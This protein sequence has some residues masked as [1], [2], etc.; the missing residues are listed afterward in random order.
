[1]EQSSHTRFSTAGAVVLSVIVAFMTGCSPDY[2]NCDTDDECKAGEF[3]VNNL[4]QQCRNDADCPTGQSCNA[5]ACE[6]VAGYC[7]SNADCDSGEE[8]QDNRCVAV[9]QSTGSGSGGDSGP[10]A[11]T[12]QSVYFDYDSS[13]LEGGSRDQLSSNAACIRERNISSVHLTGLTDPRGTEEYNMALGDR[14]A[15][16]ATKYL[17]SLGITAELSYSSMGEELATGEDESGWSRD[18]RV[19][20]KER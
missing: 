17:K 7:T 10:Q 19:D 18:R 3:C 9:A 5:G 14:R 1:M 13:N 16:A 20:F 6:T 4:C 15:Q 8:C 12:L 11:C 2:P